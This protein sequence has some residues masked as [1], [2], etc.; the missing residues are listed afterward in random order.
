MENIDIMI[1]LAQIVNF[2]IIFFIFK[3]FI[4]N[5]L[6]ETLLK[7][8]ELLA[9]LASADEEYTAILEKAKSEQTDILVQ[10]RKDAEKLLRDME[11]LSKVKGNDILKAAEKRADSIIASGKRDVEKER[12]YMM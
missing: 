4:A 7:R 5:P 9:K 2:L 10:A 6:N 8:R 1:V 11:E 3:K 12:I